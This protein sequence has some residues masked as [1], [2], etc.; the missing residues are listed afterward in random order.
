M[1]K[2]IEEKLSEPLDRPN[3]PQLEKFTSPDDGI[4]EIFIWAILFVAF[5]FAMGIVVAILL[6]IGVPLEEFFN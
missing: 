1:D 5:A 3:I 6:V 2:K 4:K